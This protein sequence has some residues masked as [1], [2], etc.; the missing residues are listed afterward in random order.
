MP[1]YLLEHF[2]FSTFYQIL[3]ILEAILFLLVSIRKSNLLLWNDFF[4]SH[5]NLHTV[6]RYD[7]VPVCYSQSV[8]EGEKIA[9]RSLSTNNTFSSF[10]KKWLN[11]GAHW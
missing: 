1:D 4:F 10:V 7:T 9:D 2:N 8:C 5:S 6:N 11:F 3:A